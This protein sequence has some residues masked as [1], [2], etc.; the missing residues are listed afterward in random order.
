[1]QGFLLLRIDK[2][3]TS[4]I[5]CICEKLHN[6]SLSKRT[7]NCDCGDRLD[8]DINSTINTMVCFIHNKALVIFWIIPAIYLVITESFF[9]LTLAT[10]FFVLWMV[11]MRSTSCKICVNFSCPLKRMDKAIVDEYL[12]KN[13][14]MRKVWEKK[15]YQL[16]V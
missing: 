14:V 10:F 16:K 9:Y 12:L 5:C 7:I 2:F 3:H 11:I 13:D 1:M 6:I 8:R 15:G 4:R